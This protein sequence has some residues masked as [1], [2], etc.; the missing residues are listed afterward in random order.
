M[1]LA[2]MYASSVRA[3][4]E[5]HS[6]PKPG[7]SGGTKSGK[8]EPNTAAASAAPI[9]SGSNRAAPLRGQ[10]TR[11]GVQGRALGDATANRLKYLSGYVA[12]LIRQQPR[13]ERRGIARVL[14]VTL[15]HL[16][17]AAISVGNVGHPRQRAWT[18][19]VDS[20]AIFQCLAASAGREVCDATLHGSVKAAQEGRLTSR[21]SEIVLTTA[22][23]GCSPRLNRSRQ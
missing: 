15:G 12:R 2:L 11:P 4:L 13:H 18:V 21:A 5:A 22:A 7:G 17:S 19:C 14:P 16:C 20:D 3:S 23:L 9:S 10:S 6:A 1:V 8:R